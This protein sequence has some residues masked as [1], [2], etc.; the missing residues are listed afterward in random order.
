VA[1]YV[2]RILKD[3]KNSELPVQ[4]PTRFEVAI[5]F[6]TWVNGPT[7]SLSELTKRSNR[8][9]CPLLAQSRHGRVH[10]SCPLSRVKRT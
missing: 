2:D 10:R 5:N 1:G 4:M 3:E 7:I 6:K 9:P 8:S